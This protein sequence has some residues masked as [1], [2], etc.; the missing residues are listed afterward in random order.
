MSA[1]TALAGSALACATGAPVTRAPAAEV[2]HVAQVACAPCDPRVSA[3]LPAAVAAVA[4]QEVAPPLPTRVVVLG[5]L[6]D[7][8]AVAG[9]DPA[10]PEAQQL[11]AWTVFDAVHLA[12]LA[13]WRDSTDDAVLARLT[14]ELCHAGV[15]QRFGSAERA[16][17]ARIPRFF[18]EGACS[19]VAAQGPAR[20]SL[21]EVRAR[22]AH[23]TPPL[24]PDSFTRDPQLAYAAAHHLMHAL[25]EHD[26]HAFRRILD[27]AVDDGAAGCVE[28]AIEAETARSVADLWRELMAHPSRS[29]A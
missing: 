20:L 12:P 24:D 11:R 6:A 29:A 1:V 5:E 7:L 23:D 10:S 17:A 26:P 16:R 15:E 19:V 13:T 8:A 22:A 25:V 4:A 21:D 18:E 2:V 3:Q 14:H 28:R 9:K 27:R